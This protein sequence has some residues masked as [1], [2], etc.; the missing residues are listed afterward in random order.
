MEQY[1]QDILDLIEWANGDARTTE[2]GRIRARDGHPKP[3]GLKYIGIGNED[4]ISDVFTER[5][6]YIFEKVKE[7]YPDIIVCGTVGPFFEGSD[8]DWGWKLATDLGVPMVDEHYYVSPGWYIHNQD[9]YDHY[10]RSKPKV[11]LGEYASHT[12]GRK[13][14]IE[15]ALTEGMHLLNVERNGDVVAM[16]SYAP[17]LCRE[18]HGNWDPDMIYFNGTEIHLTPGYYVQQMCGQNSGD[19]YIHGTLTPDSPSLPADAQRR[20]AYSCVT[21]SLTGDVIVKAASLLPVEVTA[22]LDLG[23][24]PLDGRSQVHVT[25]L[26][27]QPADRQATPVTTTATL[28]GTSITHTFAPYSFTV[29]RISGE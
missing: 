10:D 8:Y 7:R 22:T 28:T 11:Y 12:G 18:G 23:S 24:L 19:R 2:W 4:L 17:L 14:C 26:T 13:N 20:I 21:D 15:S 9:F 16:T 27:G 6:T 25:T 29:L 3:F 5:F 1:T